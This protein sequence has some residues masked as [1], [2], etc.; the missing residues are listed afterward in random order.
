MPLKKINKI[1]EFCLNE[2]LSIART[3]SCKSCLGVLS[4]YSRIDAN[5]SKREFY[6]LK[7]PK[8][9]FSFVNIEKTKQKF[10]YDPKN[11]NPQSGKQIRFHKSGLRKKSTEDLT[12]TETELRTAQGYSKIWDLGKKRWVL[13]NQILIWSCF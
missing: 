6:L 7:R 3:N 2:Y 1:C 5:V 13:S 8:I 10:G 4:Q 12:K 11:L 9:D